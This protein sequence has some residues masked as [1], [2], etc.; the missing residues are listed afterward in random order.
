M[1]GLSYPAI[2]PEPGAAVEGLL[3]ADLDA[4]I[5][6]RLDAFEDPFYQRIRVEV[7][8]W[9]GEQRPAEVY[10]LRSEASDRLGTGVWSLDSLTPADLEA[11]ISRQGPLSSDDSG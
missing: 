6:D 9:S 2:R 5:W 11:L 10:V 8:V 7:T 3:F 1:K 4:A